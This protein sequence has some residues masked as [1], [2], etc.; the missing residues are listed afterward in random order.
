MSLLFVAHWQAPDGVRVFAEVT[1]EA[2]E[3]TRLWS[4]PPRSEAE[5][6]GLLP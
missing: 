2:P 3:R 6:F 1:A 4:E 5:I